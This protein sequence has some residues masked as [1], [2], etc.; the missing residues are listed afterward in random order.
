M[1]EMKSH[2]R[3]WSPASDQHI[4]ARVVISEWDAE[5]KIGRKRKKKK[6]KEIFLLQGK[7]KKKVS[8][9]KKEKWSLSEINLRIKIWSSA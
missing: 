9:Y 8:H 3:T 5:S 6:K 4:S 1:A 2:V 7:K